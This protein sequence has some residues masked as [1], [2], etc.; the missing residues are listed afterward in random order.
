MISILY[1]VTRIFLLW[2]LW[3]IFHYIDL[4][5]SKLVKLYN[6]IYSIWNIKKVQL[7][8]YLN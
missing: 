3:L 8:R 4:C 6:S 7:N 2:D 1:D 5:D